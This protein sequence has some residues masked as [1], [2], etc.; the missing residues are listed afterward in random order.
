MP[1]QIAIL[2]FTVLIVWLWRQDGKFRPRPSRILWIPLLWFLVLGSRPVPWW[3]WFFFGVGGS[4]I[5]IEGNPINLF[6]DGG[7]IM[8]SVLAIS[9]RGFLW[10]SIG[11]KNLG[12]V[13]FFGFLGLSIL[14]SE[15]PFASFKRWVREIGSIPVLL[16]ILTEED[17]LA[18]VATVFTRAAFIL[19]SYSVLLVRYIPE[20]GRVYHGSGGLEVVGVAPQKNSLGEVVV[21]CG[22]VLVWQISENWNQSGRSLRRAP[23]LQWAITLAMGLW[24]LWQSNSKTS[25]LCLAVGSAIILSTRIP[26]LARNPRRI[27]LTF[28]ILVPLFFALDKAFQISAP[29][30]RV[31]GR[32]ATLTNRTQIWAAIDQ[33]P[34]NPVIGCGFMNYW[35]AIGS[36]DL[37]G[38]QIELKTAHNGYLDVYLDGGVVGIVFLIVFLIHSGM[39]QSR[40]FIQAIPGGALGLA[41]LCMVLL[42]N[43]SESLFARRTPL[44]I[45][46]VLFCLYIP[47]ALA[48]TSAAAPDPTTLDEADVEPSPSLSPQ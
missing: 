10:G 13:L 26:V 33:H 5:D 6:F 42:G 9:R 20:L 4:S 3:S 46:Y 45:C 31:I 36:L 48:Q 1:R 2:V 17:P 7:L 28:L 34:T 37:N 35:D 41:L 27:V 14:W 16:V 18:A 32:D 25:L 12:L 23:M 47:R 44:W 19:F 30:L 8:V 21:V 24:L 22:I 43:V 38:E 40:A 39:A 11:R 29:L 15:F